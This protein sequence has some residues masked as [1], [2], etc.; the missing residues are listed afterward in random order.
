M[1]V[2]QS[3]KTQ[4]RD[5][6]Q[7]SFNDARIPRQ[8]G[9]HCIYDTS[10]RLAQTGEIGYCREGKHY[11]VG[12]KKEMI[13]VR[14]WQVAPAGVEAVL[15]T[16]PKV[17]GAAVV[18]VPDAEQTGKLARAYIVRKLAG[19][20]AE[21]EENDLAKELKGFVAQKLARYKHLDGG[22]IFVDEIPRNAM[23]KTVKGKLMALHSNRCPPPA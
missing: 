7:I 8:P 23:G 4:R 16:H 14:G 1:T 20:C 22:V 3:T 6:R 2:L 11:I 10:F 18:D 17:L 13:K 12:R 21:P 15:L 9:G 19:S 5:V